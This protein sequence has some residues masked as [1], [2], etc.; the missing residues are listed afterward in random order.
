MKSATP[1]RAK[2]AAISVMIALALAIVVIVVLTLRGLHDSGSP[3]APGGSALSNGG[4]GN[5][6]VRPQTWAAE[7]SGAE[8]RPPPAEEIPPWKATSANTGELPPGTV[9]V[10]RVNP[11]PPDPSAPPP[12][13][14]REP[15]NP[16][17]NRPPGSP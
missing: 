17:T 8:T 13:V 11:P 1:T 15:P 12:P 2:R 10:S 3:A 4:T 9:P 5:G 16:A 14:P 7:G 6:G